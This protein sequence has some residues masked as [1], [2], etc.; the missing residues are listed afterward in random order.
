M[1]QKVHDDCGLVWISTPATVY[2]YLVP[3][4]DELDAT[5]LGGFDGQ[6]GGLCGT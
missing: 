6:Y 5:L 3:N 2:I 1:A 4:G